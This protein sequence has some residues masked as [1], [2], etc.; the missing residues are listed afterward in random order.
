M[1]SRSTYP[2]TS[3]TYELL[4]LTVDISIQCDIK[5][6]D[7]FKYFHH[8]YTYIPSLYHTAAVSVQQYV[9]GG[10]HGDEQQLPCSGP[11]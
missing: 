7:I 5:H 3:K 2:E 4:V 11:L 10:R 9:G 6:V 8:T 1:F